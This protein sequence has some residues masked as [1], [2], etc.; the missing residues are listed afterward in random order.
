VLTFILCWTK[1]IIKMKL[2]VASLLVGSAAAY[3][4]SS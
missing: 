4:P 1:I 2:A 3:A